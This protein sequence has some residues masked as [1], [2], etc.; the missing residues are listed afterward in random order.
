[1]LCTLKMT[2]L[3]A[4]LCAMPACCLSLSVSGCVVRDG[5]VMYSVCLS[6]LAHIVCRVLVVQNDCILSSCM[7]DQDLTVHCRV[8]LISQVLRFL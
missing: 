2:A 5:P 8:D 1:M 4:V 3:Q 7:L 6:L